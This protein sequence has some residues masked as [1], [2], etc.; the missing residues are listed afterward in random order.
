M[1]ENKPGGTYDIL[2]LA[3]FMSPFEEQL[4]IVGL[5]DQI[6][7]H[8]MEDLQVSFDHIRNILNDIPSM[9]GTQLEP[10]NITR[11][12]TDELF[13]GKAEDTVNENDCV[14]Y[15]DQELSDQVIS[16]IT[17]N[18]QDLDHLD[19]MLIIKYVI[20]INQEKYIFNI[21]T[22]DHEKLQTFFNVLDR[23]SNVFNY[24]V[25]NDHVGIWLHGNTELTLL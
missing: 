18:D 23:N 19:K 4:Y 5:G 12:G 17:N 14:V 7:Q 22:M 1:S 24:I 13:R 15:L 16:I 6:S 8:T 10:V 3:E 2:V 21:T 20:E 11:F 9:D 25:Q